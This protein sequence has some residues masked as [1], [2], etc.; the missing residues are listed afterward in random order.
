[1]NWKRS[2]R[3]TT[4]PSATAIVPMSFAAT[5]TPPTSYVSRPERALQLLR[6][7][8]PLPDHEPVD[9]DEQADRDD[10]DSQH[11]PPLHRADDDAVDADAARER[12][13]ERGDEGR[14][15]APA[16][17]HRERPRDVRRERRHLALGEVDDPGR[18]VDDHERERE[19][20]VD[21]ARRRG[22]ETTCCMKSEKA[23]SE[24]QPLST[25]GSSVAP[26]RSR[27]A[28]RSIP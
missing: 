22:P 27:A 19:Q 20:R 8:A 7:A 23:A 15:V 17:V 13:R 12:D 10:H 21:A 4:I 3:R 24:H 11:V 2:H 9:G 6:L 16:V 28:R 14:P 18:A 26:T 5:M 25:R 1:M